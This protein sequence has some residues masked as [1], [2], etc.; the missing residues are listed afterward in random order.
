MWTQ[1]V[2]HIA[3]Y[4][5]AQYSRTRYPALRAIMAAQMALYRAMSKCKRSATPQDM[6]LSIP[7]PIRVISRSKA[8]NAIVT[9]NFTNGE[10]VQEEH[11]IVGSLDNFIQVLKD[12]NKPNEISSLVI[13]VSL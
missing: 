6:A 9:I 2:A 13:V 5:A 12:E 10:E 11:M 8:M 1:P 7:S 3:A 4:Y